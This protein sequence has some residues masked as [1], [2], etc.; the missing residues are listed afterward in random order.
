MRRSVF[1]DLVAARTSE[2]RYRLD[3]PVSDEHLLAILE[4]ARLAPSA[5]NAQPWRFVVVRDPVV[6]TRLVEE[7][8]SGLYLRS[9]RINA[10]VFLA[11]CG[12]HGAVDRAGRLTGH[13]SYTLT[14]CGIAG[15]HAVLAAAELGLGTCWI[16]WFDR[17]K[18]QRVLGIPARVDLIALI[19]VGW[20][21][22]PTRTAP[23]ARKRKPL[24]AIA[25]LDAWGTPLP[26]DQSER[27]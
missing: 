10:P 14:D 9:R 27:S 21:A 22:D 1:R 18:A 16:G 20:P 19:A 5:E 3:R 15:E 25:A 12:V 24:S 17:R 6:R 13:C 2:R 23:P 4:A 11:L 8:F 7:A 26:A